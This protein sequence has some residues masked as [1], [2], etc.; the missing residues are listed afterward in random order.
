MY[1]KDFTPCE[2]FDTGAWRCRLMA[3][4][5]IE[6][7]KPYTVGATVARAIERIPSLREDF[8]LAFPAHSFRGLHTCS[9]CS[10]QEPAS[11]SLDQSHVNL[12]IPHRGFVF[13]APGRVDHSIETHAYQPPESFIA[14][15]LDCP[16]PLGVEYRAAIRASNRGEDAPL[17]R[18]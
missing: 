7:G 12:F 1:F 4:G 2:Y 10:A 3:I 14:A 8:R 16:S 11:P 15:L 13:V 9:I 5:W 18:S 6:R 17:Y